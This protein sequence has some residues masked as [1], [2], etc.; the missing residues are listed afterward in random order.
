[1][2]K[3]ILLICVNVVITAT[4]HAQNTFPTSDVAKTRASIDKLYSNFEL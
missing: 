3:F 4:L 1:M 2:K